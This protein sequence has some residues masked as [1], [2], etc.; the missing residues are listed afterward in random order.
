MKKVSA[1]NPL[2]HYQWGE[3]CDGWNLVDEENLSVK[4]ERMPAGTAETLHYHVRAQQF[5]FII[6]G[7]A[8]FEI[9]GEIFEIKEQEGIHIVAGKKHRII[10]NTSAAI[11]FILSSQPSTEGDRVNL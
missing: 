9:E 10:N 2:I 8:I 3:G 11:E 7:T 4:K 5:F 1:E 6:T